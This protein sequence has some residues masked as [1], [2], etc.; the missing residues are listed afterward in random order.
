[1]QYLTFSWPAIGAGPEPPGNASSEHESGRAGIAR[2]IVSWLI[3][4][5]PIGLGE[6]LLL[7]QIWRCSWSMAQLKSGVAS[8]LAANDEVLLGQDKGR[9]ASRRHWEPGT[10]CSGLP[11]ATTHSCFVSQAQ[12]TLSRWT[13]KLRLPSVTCFALHYKIFPLFIIHSTA[14]KKC[15]GRSS[16]FL[17]SSTSRTISFFPLLFKGPCSLTS[18][19]RPSSLLLHVSIRFSRPFPRC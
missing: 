15:A 7:A 9:E 12:R 6:L 1:V 5:M 19:L 13:K 18:L 16:P 2:T 11:G 10:T 14:I 8:S 17:L 4:S 3:R